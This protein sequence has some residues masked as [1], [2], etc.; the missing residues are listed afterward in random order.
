MRIALIHDWLTGMR[1]GEKV[2]EAICGIYPEADVFTLLWLRGSVSPA[3]ES[4]K[5]KTSFLQSMPMVEKKYRYYLPVMPFAAASLNVKDY[6]LII[7]SSHCVAKGV[8]KRKGATHI[9]YCHTPM[10]Y[11]WDQYDE[12]FNRERAGFAVSALMKAVRP[13][14]QRWDT[15]SSEKVDTFIS[16]SLYVKERIKRHY[17]KDAMVIYPPVDTGFYSPGEKGAGDYYLMVTALVPYKRVDLAVKAFNELG[18]KLKIVGSGP[19]SARLRNLAKA[20]IEFLGWQSDENIRGYYRECKALIFPQDE[21]FG[22]TSVEAQACGRPVIAFRKGG[23]LETV[24]EGVTGTFFGA[25]DSGSLKEAV[26]RFETMSFSDNEIRQN[27]ERFSKERFI[28]EI[29][30]VVRKTSLAI[31]S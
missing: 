28:D 14:L 17:G 8:H 7:S 23:A 2:L 27:A 10:R 31:S 19:D 13:Y 9:C 18:L 1:G 11:I 24:I 21:D 30:T 16:N 25:P 22:I 20:N 12:Y 3:I 6:D 29:K 15:G 4:H 5:I 26:K